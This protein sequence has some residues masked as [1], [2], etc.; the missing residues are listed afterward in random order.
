V[1]DPVAPQMV[2]SANLAFLFI[3][4]LSLYRRRILLKI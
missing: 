3:V 4:L 2:L 1:I